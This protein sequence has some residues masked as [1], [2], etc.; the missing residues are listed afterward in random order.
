V[1]LLLLLLRLWVRLLVV[2]LQLCLLQGQEWVLQQTD[3]VV[4]WQL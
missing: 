4:S 1:G 3:V 2:A